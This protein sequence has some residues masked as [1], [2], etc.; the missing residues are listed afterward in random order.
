MTRACLPCGVGSA[1]ASGAGPLASSVGAFAGRAERRPDGFEPVGS[2]G[3]RS[4]SAACTGRTITAPGAGTPAQTGDAELLTLCALASRLDT[5]ETDAP[6][7]S[8]DEILL[9]L[10]ALP[11]RTAIGV[12]AKV[13]LL[14]ALAPDPSASNTAASRSPEEALLA[15]LLRDVL[16]IVSRA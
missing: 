1:S 16:D 13:Q 5:D 6:T 3:T 10:S 9:R 14:I 8:W 2:A 12:R 15:S 11:A 7:A 4:G